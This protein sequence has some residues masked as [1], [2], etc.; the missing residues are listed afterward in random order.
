[1]I[2]NPTDA[3][4]SSGGTLN[5]MY[6]GDDHEHSLDGFDGL[7]GV[8]HIG[9]NIF[10]SDPISHDENGERIVDVSEIEAEF[11]HAALNNKTAE[12]KFKHYIISIEKGAQLNSLQ[13]L[14][15]ATEYLEALGFD[16]SHKWTACIHNDSEGECQHI[17]ILASLV[18]TIPAQNL[19]STSNDYAKGWPTMR[20]FEE[21]YGLQQLASPGSENDF[22][23][24]FTKNQIKGY[25]TR[26]AC[27][28]NDWGAIIRAR[29]KNLYEND[30]KPKTI[31]SF[32]LGLAKR[33]VSMQA[34]KNED[35]TVKGINYQVIGFKKNGK[36]MDSP[37]ISGS[38]VKSSRFTWTKLKNVEGMNYKP[39]RD[40]K[41][42]GLA[43]VQQNLIASIKV[44]S[45]QSRSIKMLGSRF[46]TR[47]TR[48]GYIDLSFCRT[49]NEKTMALLIK[50]VMDLLM[51][52]FER[53]QIEFYEYTLYEYEEQTNE[54]DLFN[55]RLDIVNQIET[56][57]QF[58]VW[59]HLTNDDGSGGTDIDLT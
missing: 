24:N 44:N 8:T 55:E 28:D 10:A 30:G 39:D 22:G 20:K 40:D 43:P 37:H 6:R 49:K 58:Q 18:S 25:G 14:Q 16:L 51:L 19:V 7:P 12:K 4:P 17:H 1:M 53:Q 50:T 36:I 47:I 35:G 21:L 57:T 5:Y 46:K 56:D 59:K 11:E 54:Y 32:A 42:I 31:G 27:L 13:W 41:Y 38:N 15:V 9:G 3:R 2:H 26:Q 52:L 29:I 33:N 48:A 45:R 34:V 23:L